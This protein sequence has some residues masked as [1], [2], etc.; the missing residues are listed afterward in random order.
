MTVTSNAPV[1][2]AGAPRTDAG[3]G[4]KVLFLSSVTALMMPLLGTSA[5]GPSL[6]ADENRQIVVRSGWNQTSSISRDST[7]TFADE[8]REAKELS[9]LTWAQLASVLNVR[10]R[11]VH[12]WAAG[13]PAR[14]GNHEKVKRLVTLIQ[15]VQLEPLTFRDALY[16]PTSGHKAAV[17][18]FRSGMIREAT[19]ALVAAAA[20]TS[21]IAVY[22]PV[23]PH[24]SDSSFS[25]STPLVEERVPHQQGRFVKAFDAPRPADT[26]R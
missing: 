1:A 8:L 18:L 13:R 19:A 15:S 24:R 2:Q 11:S 16:S 9:G 17:D 25:R 14:A 10:E 21:G 4:T 12:L 5:I 23:A 6:R 3:V 7:K 20:N 26:D 22:T